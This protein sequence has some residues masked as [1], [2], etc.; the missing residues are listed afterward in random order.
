M[1]VA[2]EMGI[3]FWKIFYEALVLRFLNL[4]LLVGSHKHRTL[5]GNLVR[6]LG[7]VDRGYRVLRWHLLVLHFGFLGLLV[8]PSRLVAF[9]FHAGV[10]VGYLRRLG[11]L[12]L[13]VRF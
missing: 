8:L 3:F 5:H 2:S 7:V 10:K 13:V 11:Q 9:L 12:V 6:Y 4:Q 1:L